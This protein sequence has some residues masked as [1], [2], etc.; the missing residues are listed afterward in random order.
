MCLTDELVY[1]TGVTH[2]VQGC[3]VLMPKEERYGGGFEWISPDSFP[4]PPSLKN[5]LLK[6][7]SFVTHTVATQYPPSSSED[8]DLFH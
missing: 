7:Y 4:L 8:G 1:L 3:I 5:D 6:A 2:K